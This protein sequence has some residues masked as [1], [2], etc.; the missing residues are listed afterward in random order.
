MERHIETW[1]FLELGTAALAKNPEML[2]GFGLVGSLAA[3][4]MDAPQEKKTAQRPCSPAEDKEPTTAM[5]AGGS[6]SLQPLNEPMVLLKKA[7]PVEKWSDVFNEQHSV[8]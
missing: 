7:R 3:D 4:K 1:Q 2:R 8:L 5:K 6:W